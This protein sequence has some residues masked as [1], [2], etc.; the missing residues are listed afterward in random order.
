MAAFIASVAVAAGLPADAISSVTVS[1]PA[2]RRSALPPPAANAS[3]DIAA[4]VGGTVGA[5]IFLLL[6]VGA[7]SAWMLRGSERRRRFLASLGSVV[8]V[9]EDGRRATHAHSWGA[10][11]DLVE[12]ASPGDVS[13]VATVGDVPEEEAAAAAALAHEGAAA[14]AVPPAPLRMAASAPAAPKSPPVSPAVVAA[15]GAAP[16]AGAAAGVAPAAARPPTLT[17]GRG[18]AALAVSSLIPFSE[19]ETGALLLGRGSFGSVY[20]GRLGGSEPVAVK[21]R[22]G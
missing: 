5:I 3:G 11:V 17:E 19:I 9:G 22:R 16:A 15:G 1:A 13:L 7:L 18:T 2:T 21:V 14:D 12:F 10:T 8:T 6:V 20:R 4:V